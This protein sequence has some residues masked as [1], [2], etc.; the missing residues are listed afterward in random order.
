MWQGGRVGRLRSDLLGTKPG[1]RTLC[2][3]FIPGNVFPEELYKKVPE[4]GEG[5]KDTGP[6]VTSGK[7]QA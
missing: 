6:G 4:A 5:R 1:M 3:E 2:K 7:S